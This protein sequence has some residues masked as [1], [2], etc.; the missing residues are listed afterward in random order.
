MIPNFALSAFP[1]FENGSALC[2]PSGADL[3]VSRPAAVASS[4]I[5]PGYGYGYVFGPDIV[6]AGYL[7]PLRPRL[8]RFRRPLGASLARLARFRRP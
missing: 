7:R 8:A 4:A 1:A 2:L 5:L 6:Q 3:P